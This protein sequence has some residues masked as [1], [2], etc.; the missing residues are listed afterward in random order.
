MRILLVSATAFEIAPFLEAIGKKWQLTEELYERKGLR[1]QALITGV[2]MAHTAMQTARYLQANKVDLAINAGIAGAF[3]LSIEL[4][5]VVNVVSDQFGDMGVEEADG[6]FTDVFEM[7]LIEADQFPFSKGVLQNPAAA[8]MHFLP[9]V[10][11]I[12]VNRVHG[13]EESIAAFRKQ[14]AADVE[15]MEGAA[16]ALTCLTAEVPYLQIRAISNYVESRNRA[17]WQIERAIENLC[18]VLQQIMEGLDES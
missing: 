17:N 5:K 3:D 10:K 12:T 4:G 7:G 2:G 13:N 18:N 6:S 1:L 8:S 9:L 14:Y 11:G 15:S 16:F